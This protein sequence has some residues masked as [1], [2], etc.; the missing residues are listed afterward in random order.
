MESLFDLGRDIAIAEREQEKAFQKYQKVNGE[1]GLLLLKRE[2]PQ[3]QKAAALKE[4]A[5]KMDEAGQT[6]RSSRNRTNNLYDDLTAALD[7]ARA[8]IDGD[9]RLLSEIDR[10]KMGYRLGIERSKGFGR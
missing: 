1:W 6:W 7:N 9:G 8:N 2:L 5:P 10:F 3:E 4:F